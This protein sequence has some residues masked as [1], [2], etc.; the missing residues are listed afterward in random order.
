MITLLSAPE[1]L[2]N[3]AKVHR[4]MVQVNSTEFELDAQEVPVPQDTKIVDVCVTE[5][6]REAITILLAAAGYLEGYQI[7]SYWT[8]EDGCPF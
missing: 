6:T 2:T 3:P 7:V 4:Y 8:P 5:P 1:T